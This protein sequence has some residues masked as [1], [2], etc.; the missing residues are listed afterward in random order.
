MPVKKKPEI[1]KLPLPEGHT[2]WTATVQKSKEKSQKLN[3]DSVK[4]V[5]K[6]TEEAK[7]SPSVR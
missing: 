7:S 4:I 3:Q 2:P 6:K 5:S 1:P